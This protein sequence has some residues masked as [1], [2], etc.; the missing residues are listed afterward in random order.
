MQTHIQ[1][2]EA[3][4][5]QEKRKKKEEKASPQNHS[6]MLEKRG[7]GGGGFIFCRNIC[8]GIKHIDATGNVKA[9]IY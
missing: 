4:F 8:S 7:G 2:S 9:G 6:L 1:T 3:L 5:M